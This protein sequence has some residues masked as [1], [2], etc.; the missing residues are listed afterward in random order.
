MSNNNNIR[1]LETIYSFA[2]ESEKK[3]P[4]VDQWN[5]PDCGS[6]D[7]KILRNGKWIYMGSEIKRP[8][9]TKLFSSVLRLDQ[10]GYYY[11]VTPVEKVRIEVEDAP[12]IAVAMNIANKENSQIITFV[13]NVRDKIDLSKECPIDIVI[14]KENGQP[15]PYITVRRNL[16]ALISRS[17]YYEMIEMAVEKNINNKKYL[18]LQSNNEDF[19]LYEL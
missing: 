10:D 18:T 17:V 6:I 12:F 13:T 9:L 8:A 11:L 2:K 14:N 4:P 7:M 3:I 1:G 5:P 16:K 19:K 15:S